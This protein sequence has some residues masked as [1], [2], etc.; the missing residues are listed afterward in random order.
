[1]FTF[2]GRISV[3]RE[4]PDGT[5]GDKGIALAIAEEPEA[6]DG[7]L[8]ADRKLTAEV[9]VAENKRA[10]FDVSGNCSV[11]Q[12]GPNT[13]ICDEGISLPLTDKAIDSWGAIAA[14]ARRFFTG[15][16]LSRISGLLRD[17]SMAYAF[18]AAP[19]VAIFLL[20]FRLSNLLRRLLSEGAL[21]SAFIPVFEA[22]RFQSPLR[23]ATF[24]RNLSATIALLLIIVIVISAAALGRL[25]YFIQLSPATHELFLLTALLMPGLL[26]IC[27]YGLCSAFLQCQKIYFIP[28]AAPVLFNLVWIAGVVLIRDQPLAEAMSLLACIVVFG[29][30]CQWLFTLPATWNSLQQLG[31]EAVWRGIRLRTEEVRTL[32]TPLA[33]GITGVAATQV[34]NA[35]DGFFAWWAD[36]SGP[37]YLWYAIR[38]QQLPMALWGVAMSGALLPPLCRLAK[39]S[40]LT[41]FQSSFSQAMKKTIFWMMLATAWFFVAGPSCVALLFGR[42]DFTG[43]DIAM[44]TYCL[45][46]Y[47]I[48][49]VPAVLVLIATAAFYSRGQFRIPMQASFLAVIINS[50][51]NAIFIGVLDKGVVSVAIATSIA[52][53][54]NL[55]YLQGMLKRQGREVSCGKMYGAASFVSAVAVLGAIASELW[56]WGDSPAYQLLLGMAPTY[57]AILTEPLLR[58]ITEGIAFL[59]CGAVAYLG[60]HSRLYPN[61]VKI[62]YTVGR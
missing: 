48:G 57:S 61:V 44:T 46:G 20:A 17:M 39:E 58:L 55:T 18:G 35:L 7:S 52:A 24:F 30:L 12:K 28:A 40:D 4:A 21:Q 5:G 53:A 1:M 19:L 42:G 2:A 49:L 50:T 6:S 54:V 47:I 37:A 16:A 36:P 10:L 59:C 23:A 41:A 27:L 38:L 62:K 33:M 43:E 14:S 26:F 9:N 25:A 13:A 34:N 56:L 29:A 31:L 45:W 32:R 15:T 60:M 8:A 51:L 11:E 22:L 3:K